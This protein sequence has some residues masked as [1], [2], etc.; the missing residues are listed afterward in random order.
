MPVIQKTIQDGPPGLLF[1]HS[2][3]AQGHKIRSWE[4]ERTGSEPD[5][6]LDVQD[7]SFLH[8]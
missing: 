6:C 8:M 2:Q 4:P 1:S 5:T 3:D 7:N